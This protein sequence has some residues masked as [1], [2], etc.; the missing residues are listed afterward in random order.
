MARTDF[1]VYALLDPKREGKFRFRACSLLEEPFYVG[2]GRGRRAKLH[3]C[4]SSRSAAQQR[5]KQMESVGIRPT[6]LILADGLMEQAALDRERE[7]IALFG[8][9]NVDGGLLL[10]LAAGGSGSSG[11]PCPQSTRE[12]VSRAHLGKPKGHG[13]KI[14]AAKKGVPNTAAIGK[15]RKPETIE[16]IRRA[17][18]GKARPHTAGRLVSDE[19]RAK[20]GAKHKGKTLSESARQQMMATKLAKLT[21][22]QRERRDARLK[23]ALGRD[24]RRAARESRRAVMAAMSPEDRIARRTRTQFKAGHNRGVPLSA[25]VLAKLRGSKRSPEQ[26]ARLSAAK[27]GKP[28]LKLRGRSRPPEVIAKMKATKAAKRRNAA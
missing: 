4:P 12:A 11:L 3:G 26:R 14:S 5:I 17:Q 19:T 1:Y 16:K 28:N 8:R 25:D 9:R 15:P 6:I 21:P 24:E 20:I 18:A 13:A 2:K 23:V 10:N 22:D 7:F 27:K